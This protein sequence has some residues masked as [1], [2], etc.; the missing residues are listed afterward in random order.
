[1]RKCN[2][3]KKERHRLTTCFTFFAV[4]DSRFA[5]GTRFTA[6]GEGDMDFLD[7]SWVKV[8]VGGGTRE[9][10]W[11]MTGDAVETM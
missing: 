2:H 7:V 3:D 4:F 11:I 5:V 6:E 1:M 9:R 8:N 10:G